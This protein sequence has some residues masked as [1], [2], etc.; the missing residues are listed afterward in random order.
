MGQRLSF[1]WC[2]RAAQLSGFGLA[3]HVV[4]LNT[5]HD[6][7]C[8]G[9]QVA[10]GSTRISAGEGQRPHVERALFSRHQTACLISILRS[11]S[12]ISFRYLGHKVRAISGRFL[13][14]LSWAWLFR[15]NE[16]L[17]GI[18]GGHWEVNV[19]NG[20][21]LKKQTYVITNDCCF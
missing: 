10:I 14:R 3:K 19:P 6:K 7:Y 17:L 13:S 1:S 18:E 15:G 5:S 4:L 21:F 9:Q 16:V 2:P 20:L 8:Y 11:R 12:A